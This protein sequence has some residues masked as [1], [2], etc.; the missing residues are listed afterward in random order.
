MSIGY[1]I[2]FHGALGTALLM[3][4]LAI[5]PDWSTIVVNFI[6]GLL[7]IY[8]GIHFAERLRRAGK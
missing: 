1:R 3:V 7:N 8:L 4:L 2:F 6:L 5:K